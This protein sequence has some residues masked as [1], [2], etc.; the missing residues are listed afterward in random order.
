[1]ACD[2]SC[3]D[4]IAKMK[5]AMNQMLDYY[6]KTAN[7]L[8]I[9]RP[10]DA[11]DLLSPREVTGSFQGLIVTY[12]V[13]PVWLWRF[14]ETLIRGWPVN[15]SSYRYQRDWHINDVS[16]VLAS[17]SGMDTVNALGKAMAAAHKKM[18]ILP[19]FNFDHYPKLPFK[20]LGLNSAAYPATNAAGSAKIVPGVSTDAVVLFS[21]RLWGQNGR[22]GS[23][24]YSGPGSDADEVLFHEMIHGLRLMVGANSAKNTLDNA[25]DN[26]EEF[27]AVVL[28]NIYMAETGTMTLRQDH[29]GFVP[30][31]Q[32][33]DFLKNPQYQNLLRN[34]KHKQRG[35]YNDLADIDIRK[36]WWNPVRE[37]RA[38]E[39]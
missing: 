10:A 1:M 7:R 20:P 9:E 18:T 11:H 16:K 8:R 38:A 24:G 23:F 6:Q 2:T 39:G 5:K 22:P 3:Q 35:F 19:F 26:E 36:A 32:P 13:F 28:T 34:F 4:D 31:P 29:G 15:I 12:F 33:R 30:M 25:Y 14:D 17:F 37:F 21:P 27:I